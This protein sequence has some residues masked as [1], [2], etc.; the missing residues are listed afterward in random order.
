[1]LLDLAA[2][3]RKVVYPNSADNSIAPQTREK[4]P[5]QHVWEGAGPGAASCF[6]PVGPLRTHRALRPRAPPLASARRDVLSAT[7]PRGVGH[8]A[9]PGAARGGLGLDHPSRLSRAAHPRQRSAGG[10]STPEAR[11]HV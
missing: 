6:L 7:A 2:T 11:A 9:G 5:M 8:P 10:G 1:M 4:T 3:V